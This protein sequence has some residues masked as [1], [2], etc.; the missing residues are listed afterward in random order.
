MIRHFDG[1]NGPQISAQA[2]RG[3]VWAVEWTWRKHRICLTAKEAERVREIWKRWYKR[4]G[5]KVSGHRAYH[6]LD[7]VEHMRSPAVCNV[8]KYDPHT[9]SVLDVR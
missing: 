9:R 5:W 7:K 8:V 6:P 2:Q 3:A 4:R 1:K